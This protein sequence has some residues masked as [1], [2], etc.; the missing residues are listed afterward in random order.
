MAG[1]GKAPRAEQFSPRFENASQQELAVA[2]LRLYRVLLPA[3]GD[4][5]KEGQAAMDGALEVLG[6]CGV[7]FDDEGE[8][9]NLMSSENAKALMAMVGEK[10]PAELVEALRETAD[11]DALVV[12]NQAKAFGC[13]CDLEPWMKPD[14]CVL[15]ESRAEDCTSARPL[16]A[17]GKD[18]W[19]CNDWRV[20]TLVR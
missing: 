4:F 5:N 6:R 19:H 16:L 12:A 18:K 9:V 3:E 1:D 14:G 17:A 20:V 15:D 8:R 11:G 7:K 13:H 10:A 2:L